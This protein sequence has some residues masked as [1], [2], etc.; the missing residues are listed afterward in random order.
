MKEISFLV[1]FPKKVMYLEEKFMKWKNLFYK[2]KEVCI[3]TCHS[4]TRYIVKAKK[5][6]I[7]DGYEKCGIVKWVI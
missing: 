2:I 5:N 4:D 3:Q 1:S 6:A 7:K